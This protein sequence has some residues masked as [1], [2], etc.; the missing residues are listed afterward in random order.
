MPA[1]TPRTPTTPTSRGVFADGR[2]VLLYRTEVSDSGHALA[3]DASDD[4][5]SFLRDTR[6]ATLRDERGVQMDPRAAANLRIVAD[7]GRYLMTFTYKRGGGAYQCVAVSAD[8]LHW[9]T[10]GRIKGVSEPTV[11]IPDS[12]K[13][14][15]YVMLAGG[16]AIRALVS[17]DLVSWTP[18]SQGVLSEISIPDARFVVG[19]ARA[20]T[21]RVVL[22]YYIS[23][24]RDGHDRFAIHTATLRRTNPLERLT[25]TAGAV[26]EQTDQWKRLSVHPIGLADTDRN[27]ISYW[28]SPTGN[29]FTIFHP[30]LTKLSSERTAGPSVML[31][32][33]R[34]NP[35]LTPKA[36][37]LWETKAV[38]NPA[39]VYED[40]RVHLMYR[41]IGDHDRSM[42]GYA[43]STDGITIDAR[44]ENPAYYPTEPFEGNT[45]DFLA[46]PVARPAGPYES[47]GGGWGGC[48]DP[49]LTRIGDTMY[50]TYVAYDGWTGPRVALTSIPM[51][52]FSAKRWTWK[53]PVL[54]S[55]PG[56]VDKNCV[57]FPETVN[58]K[59]VI[60]HR[61]FP[62]LLVDYVD[63]L[64]AFDGKT[65]F[66]KR[67]GD[68][69]I[70]PRPTAW[71][72]RK[73]GAG[74]PPIKTD[75]GWLLIYHSVDDR[76]PGRYKMGAML[77]DH[78]D[79]TRVLARSRHPILAPDMRYE[80]EGFKAGVAYPCGAVVMGDRL[81]VYYGGADTVVCAAEAR[82]STFLDDLVGN[83]NTA[84]TP[85]R[86]YA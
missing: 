86:V 28:E 23:Y 70:P 21:D 44:D 5:I 35:I 67:H 16:N 10:V 19:T 47:G 24:T 68:A 9:Q 32:R 57:I 39:A 37:S 6:T 60:F 29:I 53:K 17:D 40:G 12:R 43:T 69:V 13:D 14:G 61:I 4:G 7:D 85:A 3:L 81:I 2:R 63:S 65:V 76:D 30:P 26:W 42:I 62:D 71:D 1:V 25:D 50:M 75:R 20:D 54:I 34:E 80:N 51:D 66:L 64:S 22:A 18:L 41:A 36:G 72:S 33:A 38:F 73:I 56:V 27:L 59:Y 78:Y 55:P 77:L 15:A 48:E 84:F 8:T 11:I 52:D 31:S 46:Q 45:P 82:L 58:G 79:P 74:P 83:G 49:R